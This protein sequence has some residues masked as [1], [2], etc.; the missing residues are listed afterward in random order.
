VRVKGTPLYGA[1]KLDPLE[2]VRT[3]ATARILMPKSMVRLSAGRAEMS[4]ELQALCFFAGANSIFYGERLLTTLNPK[5][6][7]DKQLFERLG[8]QPLDIRNTDESWP[9]A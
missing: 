5:V 8:L 4:K 2:F 3:V 1:E 6:D 9:S 7:A